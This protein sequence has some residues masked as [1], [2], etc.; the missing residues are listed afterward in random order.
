MK[1]GIQNTK[2]GRGGS[3][4]RSDELAKLDPSKAHCELRFFGGLSIE[5]TSRAL[6]LSPRTVKR[7]WATAR[8]CCI[9]RMSQGQQTHDAGTLATD[10]GCWRKCWNF[11][12]AQRSAFLQRNCSTD[13]SLR[14]ESETLL[15]SS[16]DVRSSFCN[17]PCLGRM[18]VVR[19]NYLQALYGAITGSFVAGQR[20]WSCMKPKTRAGRLVA[21]KLCQIDDMTRRRWNVSGVKPTASA[22]KSSRYLYY[23]H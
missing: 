2:R 23:L 14:Q 20:P 17:P 7:H 15:A 6:N 13:P 11:P 19:K 8:L 10:S 21:I 12:A 3:R 16:P 5:E 9:T 1:A 4:P 22:F 18:T